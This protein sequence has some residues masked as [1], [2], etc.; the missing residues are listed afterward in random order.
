MTVSKHSQKIGNLS[1]DK[2]E[3]YLSIRLERKSFKSSYIQYIYSN[4]YLSSITHPINTLK[5][6]RLN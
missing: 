2:L 1:S 6:D 4:I 3:I 5:S